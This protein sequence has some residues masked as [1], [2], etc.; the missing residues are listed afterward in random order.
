MISV[1][2]LRRDSHGGA[3]YDRVAVAIGQVK[4]LAW[5][6]AQRP[7][8][9]VGRPGRHGYNRRR[10]SQCEGMKKAASVHEARN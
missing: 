3:G 10:S 1:K 7:D 8:F 5:V 4:N 9:R 6:G 2:P